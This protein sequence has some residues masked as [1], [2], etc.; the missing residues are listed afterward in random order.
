MY[1]WTQT[2][3]IGPAYGTSQDTGKP[4]Q[5]AA[6]SSRIHLEYNVQL[7]CYS[8]YS[9]MKRTIDSLVISSSCCYHLHFQFQT[10]KSWIQT[11]LTLGRPNP[12]RSDQWESHSICHSFAQEQKRR[13]QFAHHDAANAATNKITQ[14]AHLHIV[15]KTGSSKNNTHHAIRCYYIHFE[16]N[17]HQWTVKCT[18]GEH[19]EL[20]NQFIAASN[21]KPPWWTKAIVRILREIK[22]LDVVS[23]RIV[24]HQVRDEHPRERTNHD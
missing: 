1:H 8:F 21:E 3:N 12:N 19:R 22:H 2:L 5:L 10:T 16:V 20:C 11:Q 6:I 14:N 9:D 7:I 18:V 24:T 23:T 4:L 13:H 17:V 15:C